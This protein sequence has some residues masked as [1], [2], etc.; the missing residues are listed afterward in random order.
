MF[1]VCSFFVF[2]RDIGMNLWLVCLGK[3]YCGVN[4]EVWKSDLFCV[5]N[6]ICFR[7]S[8]RIVGCE[9]CVCVGCIFEWISR[10]SC[11]FLRVIYNILD[12]RFF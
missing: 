3:W 5:G 6:F 9:W 7:V 2:G 10:K 1:K 8:S 4:C 11:K 12:V